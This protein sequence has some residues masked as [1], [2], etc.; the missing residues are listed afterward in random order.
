MIQLHRTNPP[1]LF[2]VV[3][4]A[5]TEVLDSVVDSEAD[6]EADTEVD[7]EVK[8]IRFVSFHHVL[9][10]G[11]GTDRHKTNYYKQFLK[12]NFNNININ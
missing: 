10:C 1:N 12:W 5:D 2:Q 7:T 6:T 8:N 11:V 9:L 3:S 4:E